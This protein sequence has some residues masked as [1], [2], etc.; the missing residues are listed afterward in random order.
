M[1]H[2]GLDLT[3]EEVKKLKQLALRLDASVK[4]L[5]TKLIKTA[6]NMDDPSKE[7]QKS[8]EN[9]KQKEDTKK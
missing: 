9:K 8:K 6:I 4:D 5:V 7:V 3:D 1:Y 2:I